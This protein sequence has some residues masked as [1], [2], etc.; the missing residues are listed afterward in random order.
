MEILTVLQDQVDRSIR[1]RRRS[2]TSVV[3]LKKILGH[4][5]K[6]FSII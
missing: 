5:R 4:H 1:I 6:N 2:H 3:E